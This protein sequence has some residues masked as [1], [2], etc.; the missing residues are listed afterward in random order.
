MCKLPIEMSANQANVHMPE[1]VGMSL[2]GRPIYAPSMGVMPESG[3]P[4]PVAPSNRGVPAATAQVESKQDNA[5]IP[6]VALN[7]PTVSVPYEIHRGG[8]PIVPLPFYAVHR[9]GGPIVPLPINVAK[10]SEPVAQVESK[11]DIGTRILE[12]A[13]ANC[14]DT[15]PAGVTPT[16]SEEFVTNWHMNRK[17]KLVVL[18]ND[19]KIARDNESRFK[20]EA[21][22]LA[23]RI[24]ELTIQLENMKRTHADTL[25]KIRVAD[26]DLTTMISQHD[27]VYSDV[28]RFQRILLRGKFDGSSINL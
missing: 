3:L 9:G 27:K 19:I 12:L 7:Y 26:S 2:S 13:R 8:G 24:T 18:E 4:E 16:C 17:N 20:V 15:L 25:V 1:I 10:T 5:H 14:S 11:Q 22:S 6:E 21:D 23:Q 28:G